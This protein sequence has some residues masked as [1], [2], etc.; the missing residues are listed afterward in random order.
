MAVLGELQAQKGS[1]NVKGKI[2]Y[3]SQ[4][5]WIFNGSLKQNI[6]FGQELNEEKYQKVIKVCALERVSRALCFVLDLQHEISGR[7]GSCVIFE[8]QS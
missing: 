7:K 2:A 6:T 8:G 1:V 4:E 5:A 3:S